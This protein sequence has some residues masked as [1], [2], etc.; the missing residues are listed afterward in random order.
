MG[1]ICSRDKETVDYRQNDNGLYDGPVSVQGGFCGNGQGE[2]SDWRQN[3]SN[4]LLPLG[5]GPGLPESQFQRLK[6]NYG[7]AGGNKRAAS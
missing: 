2:E 4:Q 5:A 3:D 7:T 1:T 6:D